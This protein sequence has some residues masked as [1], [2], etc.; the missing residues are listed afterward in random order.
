M[1]KV[2]DERVVEMRFDNRHFEQNV[3]TSMS[4][5]DKLK[6]ALNFKG[7]SKGLENLNTSVNKVNMTPLGKG[8]ETVHAKFSAL[9]VM[10]VT[11]LANITN[12]AVN[13]G[14]RIASAL[15]IDPI[16]TGFSE[17]ETQINAV[18]TI[19]ANTS[20][21]GTTLDQVNAAL[22]E[23]NAYAD[24]TIYNFT[25][26]TRNIGTF[27]AAGVDLETSVS[28]IQGI[29]NVAAISGSTSQQAS[30]AMYQLSQALAAGRV[31]LM[32][33][34]SVVNAGMGGE[35]FQSALRETSELLGTGAEAAIKAKGS[36]RESLRD[37]WLTAEVLTETLKKFTT[38][39]ANEYVA[40]YTGL[41]Q[42][43]VK[44]TLDSAKAQYGEADAI[45]EAAKALAKKSGKS[46]EEIKSIL[47]MAKTSEDAATKVK[48]LSQLWDTLKEAAQ[49]GW[50]QTWEIVVGDF[51]EAKKLFTSVSDTLGGV[52]GRFS[53][54]R[55]A[56]LEGALNITSPWTKIMDKLDG[57]GLGTIKKV[58]DT[59]EDLTGKLSKYQEVVDKVWRGDFG[60]ADTGRYDKLD[61]AGWDHRVIQDLVN[62]GQDYKITVKDVEESHK[63]FGITMKKSSEE[64]KSAT[65]ALA[66]LSDEQLKNAGLTESEIKLYKDL[67]EEADK[68]GISIEE[69]VEKM[70]KKD[71]RTLLIESFKNA[72]KGLASIFKAVH[73]A[74]VDI[75][76]PMSVVKLYSIIEG[77]NEF[78]KHLVVGDE[79]AKNLKRTLKGVFA[80]IDIIGTVLGGGLKF[81]IKTIAT[82]LGEAD[83]NILSLTARIS[84]AIVKLRDWID[85]HNPLTK[86]LKAVVPY[87]KRAGEAFGD[88][89]DKLKE[90][91]NLP[92]DILQGLINGLKK[93]VQQ[94]KANAGNIGETILGFLSPKASALVEA[95][96]NIISGIIEGIKNGISRIWS[97]I[98][99]VVSKGAEAIQS[100]DWGSIIAVSILGGLLYTVNK[101]SDVISLFAKPLEGVGNLLD[102]LGEMFEGIG[103][104]I[105]A[106]AWK[107]KSQALLNVAISL[108]ILVAAIYVLSKMDTNSLIRGGIALGILAGVLVGLSVAIDKLHSV[109]ASG[110][111]TAPIIAVAG[112]LLIVAIALKTLA[113]IKLED[114]PTVLITLG[115]CVFGMCMIL[116]S[117][118]KMSS[119]GGSKDI[120]KAGVML[121]KMSVAL[122]IMTFVIKQIAKLKGEDIAQ[123]LIVIGL[124]ELM[125]A[126]VIK[127]SAKAGEYGDKAGA[128]L[129]KMSIAML[130]MAGLI[131]IISTFSVGEIIKGLGAIVAMGLVFRSLIKMS[132]KAGANASKTGAMLLKM[133][134][135]MLIMAGVMKIVGGMDSTELFQGLT[136]ILIM[137]V[138]FKALVKVSSS[139]GANATKAGAM[140]LLM[141]GALLIMTGVMWLLSKMDSSG[142]IKALSVISIL[143][144]V[145]A[146]LMVAS[147]YAGDCK[148]ELIVLTVAIGLM[149]GVLIALSFIDPNKLAIATAAL[150]GITGVFA[151]LIASTKYA[152]KVDIA[153]LVA[154]SFVMALMATIVAIMMSMDLSGDASSVLALSALLIAMAASL[155][156]ID[157]IKINKGVMTSLMLM[158]V[159]VGEL[160]LILGLM[161]TVGKNGVEAS[162]QTA[163]A[164]S[165][166]LLAMSASLLILSKMGTFASSATSAIVPMILL[167]V[168]VAEL[169]VILGIMSGLEIEASIGTATALSI[170]L[171]AM[172]GVLIVL[173]AVGGLAGVAITGALGMIAVIG[174]IGAFVVALGLLSE[175]VP[176]IEEFLN[177]GIPILE[178]IGVAIG[179]FIGSII[180]GFADAVLDILPIFGTKLSEFMDNMS[181]FIEGAKNLEGVDFG[182]LMALAAGITAFLAVNVIS[183]LLEAFHLMG[184]LPELGTEL[185]MFMT[186]L[187]PFIM[188]AS[189]ITPES[190]EGVKS[191]A[192]VILIL[193]AANLLDGITKF[194]GLGETSLS[195]F[196]AELKPFAEGMVAYS[197]TLAQ[198]NFNGDLVEKSSNAAKALA[199]VADAIPSTGGWKEKIFGLK[200]LG[201]FGDTLVPFAEGMI[202]YC[203]V[204]QNGKF[205]ADTVEKS[206]NA[207]Q[208]LASL[209]NN[210][211]GQDGWIQ[212][213]TGIKDLGD[214]GGTLITFAEGMVG[215]CDAL[216]GSSFDVD[217]VETSAN[218]GTMLSDLANSLP[219]QDGWA[220]TILGSQSLDTFG[221]D[222]KTYA[223]GMKVYSEAMVGCN[224]VAIAMGT[225]AGQCLSD[226]VDTLPKQDGW[227]QSIFGSKDLGNFGTTIVEFGE[228]MA[229]YSE[230]ISG[231]NMVAVG[232]TVAAAQAFLE[233]GKL[234][235]DQGGGFDWLVADWS[236]LG[237]NMS[238]FGSAMVA[239]SESVV[240]LQVAPIQNS[241][242]AALAVISIG[243]A[244]PSG[245]TITTLFGGDATNLAS[246]GRQAVSFGKSLKSY[247]NEVAALKVS[248]IVASKPAAMALCEIGK[249]IPI[250]TVNISPFAT[251]LSVLGAG[252][253][254]Y[255][256]SVAGV[257]TTAI[258]SSITVAKDLIA[259]VKDLNGI[260]SSGAT[261]FKNAINDLAK[262][263]VADFVN[264]FKMK[265]GEIEHVGKNIII[266]LSKGIKSNDKSALNATKTI[267]TNMITHLNTSLPKFNMLGSKTMHQFAN[268]V[269]KGAS[270]VRIAIITP[271]T[272]M[273][274]VLTGYYSSFYSAGSYLVSG[275]A[276]GISA[277]AYKAVAKT[278]A[279]ATAAKQAAEEAL[280]IHSPSRVFYEFGEFTVLGF[281]NAIDD[282]MGRVYN[283]TSDMAE[284]ARNGIS[285]AIGKISDIINSDI[286]AEPTIRPVLDLSDVES[287]SRLINGMFSNRLAIGATADVGSISSMMNGT[288]QNGGND[289]VISAIDKLR[290]S[291]GNIGGNTYNVNGVTY[292]DGSNVSNAV[293]SLVRAARIER[294]V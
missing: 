4:T 89:I 167:G 67:A 17:Y 112:S 54:A 276:S 2:I 52:I 3:K 46:E 34:N 281:T 192:E 225:A 191:L 28:A 214:F 135:A 100:I 129:L 144:L 116:K 230:S 12:S 283:S 94:I 246:F 139:A 235:S 1:S 289:D 106:N 220:Q 211:P 53:D 280:G 82:L 126:G 45:N 156:L 138:V 102:G 6:N 193:T 104:K 287:G 23:L 202:G 229:A 187:I 203:N 115:A 226:L 114:V 154:M 55:N 215:Y 125:F 40:K 149:A 223:D 121:L 232:A 249:N 255:G 216:Q 27:T 153:S 172:S 241:L 186:N 271:I 95:G 188:G 21:D 251:Q 117:F 155:K 25:E 99:D 285:S 239:Y 238:A 91:D 123:G 56:L 199:G 7:A 174:I 158:G 162:I 41:S 77:I 240:G 194:L 24:K 13:A 163:G 268:G 173:S 269:L 134:V 75:F 227:A 42:E 243:K 92:K 88:W 236:A 71:G 207:A 176:Q 157:K 181:G 36:F 140:L 180:S 81:V 294:R 293:K 30:T 160:A 189:L 16:K 133:S 132:T 127:A 267:I 39:G 128:M 43:A 278:R 20:K 197:N 257:N 147:G 62:K 150:M 206:A 18:Q 190:M 233:L 178:K 29:A 70:S 37:G 97:T 107:K 105:K 58:S 272:S 96:G 247:G 170:L 175:K 291:L 210:I 264:A 263:N 31:S 292:D 242:S 261:S 266:M 122:L 14:K 51:E 205:D 256:N 10:G 221:D 84:D 209:A 8:I 113:S 130:I 277:N 66:N 217:L 275:F 65:S 198:G 44:A 254:G 38:S 19:M 119:V 212:K 165:I 159:V 169:A 80:V 262:S 228:G 64:T 253:K 274:S 161:S 171:L 273:I 32:D 108:G 234:H 184:P 137:G 33:W 145:F 47:N 204:L 118:R 231:F 60:N 219:K 26:M 270:Y 5:L 78:S 11:A 76:P 86:V 290:D 168:V 50:S 152:G 248:S 252:L 109:D 48:T 111:K 258:T 182:G 87:L 61:K 201:Q 49:S 63:K 68:T 98:L 143:S 224:F 259:L 146:G 83:V 124:L 166:L 213:I 245:S 260:N 244:L 195:S 85:A 237:P 101:M 15:T 151:L 69:L 218:A 208:A 250:I 59:V 74:W 22:D 79:T 183:S 142:L 131:K 177:K 141:S 148:S 222:L 9:E 288:I 279:M 265:S 286:D 120:D 103:A 136:A 196:A 93:G 200:D 73:D 35:V 110:V 72:W 185:S 282:N 90:S 164:I 57:A 284:N 179:S